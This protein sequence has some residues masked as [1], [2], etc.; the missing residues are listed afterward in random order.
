MSQ[1]TKD[2]YVSQITVCFQLTQNRCKNTT[3]NTG[4][5]F[6]ETNYSRTCIEDNQSRSTKPA[7]DDTSMVNHRAV[8]REFGTITKQT[9][10]NYMK[11]QSRQIGMHAWGEG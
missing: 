5:S 10:D 2:N 3:G 11:R 9:L 1:I 7:W 8:S 4:S 6:K